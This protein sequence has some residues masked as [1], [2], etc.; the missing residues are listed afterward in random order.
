M[1]DPSAWY[2][3][4]AIVSLAL[5][6]VSI[7]FWLL[8]NSPAPFPIDDLDPD[9][10]SHFA[11]LAFGVTGGLLAVGVAITQFV[12]ERQ[13]SRTL[14]VAA[15]VGLPTFAWNAFLLWLIISWAIYCAE[16]PCH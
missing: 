13:L 14:M 3:R 11:A 6:A 15:L 2:Q 12:K 7:C 1:S 4:L 10:Y 8:V 5:A 16:G 9:G